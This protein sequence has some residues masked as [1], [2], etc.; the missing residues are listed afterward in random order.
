MPCVCVMCL[1]V[2]LHVCV[3]AC[4]YQRSTSTIIT[5]A[6]HLVC[7]DKVSHW[8]PGPTSSARL[9]G[10]LANSKDLQSLPSEHCDYMPTQQAS[11]VGSQNRCTD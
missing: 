10:W 5:G 4:E 6:V 7:G 2:H 8:D 1:Q 3:C 11:S 9:A